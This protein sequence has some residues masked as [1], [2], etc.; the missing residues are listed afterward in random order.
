MYGTIAALLGAG[1][2]IYFILE[3]TVEKRSNRGIKSFFIALGENAFIV[4][5]LFLIAL[6]IYYFA[7]F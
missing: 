6:T 1:L 7:L 5:P 3:I 4:I 2:L